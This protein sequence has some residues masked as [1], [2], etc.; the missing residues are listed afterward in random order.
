MVHANQLR[1]GTGEKILLP[2]LGTLR[3]M[4]LG[5]VLCV[6]SCFLLLWCFRLDLRCFGSCLAGKSLWEVFLWGQS[7]A[8]VGLL[9][10]EEERGVSCAGEAAA[11]LAPAQHHKIAPKL[12]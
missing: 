10:R 9:G 7:W 11:L 4:P 1:W 12:M 6:G 2:L 5:M 3:A 8:Q